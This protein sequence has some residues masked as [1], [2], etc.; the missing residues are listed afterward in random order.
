MTARARKL[1]V[2]PA[3]RRKAPNPKTCAAALKQLRRTYRHLPDEERRN[4][5]HV[6]TALRGPDASDLWVKHATTAVIR[7]HALGGEF[8]YGDESPDSIR[9]AKQRGEMHAEQQ[10]GAY[11]IRSAERRVPYHF[12]SHARRAFEAL[13]LKWELVNPDPEER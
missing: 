2:A 10:V 3:L 13:G 4:L 5:W 6:L 1:R 11:A 7:H 12:Y 9:L 8:I